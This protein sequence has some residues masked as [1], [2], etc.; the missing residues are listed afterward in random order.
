MHISTLCFCLLGG[1]VGHDGITGVLG[2]SLVLPCDYEKD[3]I[4]VRRGDGLGNPSGTT[5]RVSLRQV[6]LIPLSAIGQR[7]FWSNFVPCASQ[8]AKVV[9]HN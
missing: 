2:A 5:L 4:K 1:L 7:L 3:L 9:Y 6:N 8:L